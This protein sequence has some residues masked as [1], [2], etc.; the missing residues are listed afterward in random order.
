MPADQNRDFES[1]VREALI[2]QGERQDLMNKDL[3]RVSTVVQTTAKQVDITGSEVKKVKRWQPVFALA[4][5]CALVLGIVSIILLQTVQRKNESNFTKLQNESSLT[6]AQNQSLQKNVTDIDKKVAQVETKVDTLSSAVSRSISRDSSNRSPSSNQKPQDLTASAFEAA[7]GVASKVGQK[8]T[9]SVIVVVD[10][11]KGHWF[12]YTLSYP[13]SKSD[14]VISVIQE[15]L[16]VKKTELPHDREKGIVGR[17][18]LIHSSA[19]DLKRLDENIKRLSFPGLH[20]S[21]SKSGPVRF[22]LSSD[23]MQAMISTELLAKLRNFQ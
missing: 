10:L 15:S 8:Q 14:L 23:E 16:A 11:V 5:S 20:K 18:V 6:S 13:P 17:F 9:A 7:V 19:H 3:S 2:G 4:I 21:T 1:F 22:G 12:E